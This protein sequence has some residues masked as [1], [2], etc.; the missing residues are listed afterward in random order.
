MSD[1]LNVGEFTKEL[2]AAGLLERK[3]QLTTQEIIST[4][5]NGPDQIDAIA[6]ERG[7]LTDYPGAAT[8]QTVKA[9]MVNCH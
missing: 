6:A 2:P 7:W 3:Q 4:I 1:K 9:Y 5:T 8:C